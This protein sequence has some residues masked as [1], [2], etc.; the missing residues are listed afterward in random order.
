MVLVVVND[1]V[2]VDGGCAG[3][4]SGN[5]A[6]VVA[7]PHWLCGCISFCFWAVVCGAKWCKAGD[8][9]VIDRS[10]DD[11]LPVH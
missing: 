4:V 6:D 9:S 1:V 7:G 2:I 5:V 8:P 10:V 3:L 11:D